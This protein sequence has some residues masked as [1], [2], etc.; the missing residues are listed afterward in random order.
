MEG[1][2]RASEFQKEAHEGE[3][4]RLHNADRIS[5]SVSILTA[6][7]IVVWVAVSEILEMVSKKMALPI[8]CKK[9]V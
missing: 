7:N 3:Y 9:H 6:H 8:M 5:L 2:G 1:N 4:S